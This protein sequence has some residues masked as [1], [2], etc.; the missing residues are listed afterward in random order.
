MIPTKRNRI[1]KAKQNLGPALKKC[2]SENITIQPDEASLVFSNSSRWVEVARELFLGAEAL[3]TKPTKLIEEALKNPDEPPGIDF[4]S[5]FRSGLT[6]LAFSAENAVKAAYLLDHPVRVRSTGQVDLGRTFPGR[7][8]DLAA[9]A[10]ASSL[11][12]IVKPKET[13]EHLAMFSQ[14]VRWSGR[15]PY[16]AVV[17]E[18][19]HKR[20]VLPDSLAIV[21]GW[22]SHV[23]GRL[24]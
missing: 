8:H 10:N 20:I 24:P 1:A 19:A 5:R 18:R 17:T 15:Y 21:W 11:Q 6:L 14:I 22:I 7:A 16:S 23:E 9:I 13:Q 2:R 12:P 3:L 4:R